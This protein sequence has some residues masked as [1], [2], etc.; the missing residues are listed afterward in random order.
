MSDVAFIPCSPVAPTDATGQ[1]L[2][3]DPR[4]RTET[5]LALARGID[6]DSAYDRLPVLADA[7]EEAGCDLGLLLQHC[8]HCPTHAPGC[9]AVELILDRVPPSPLPAFSPVLITQPHTP[10]SLAVGTPSPTPTLLGMPVVRVL[11]VVAFAGLARVLFGP[12]CSSRPSETPMQPPVR[13]P[14]APTTTRTP[15]QQAVIDSLL[16]RQTGRNEEWVQKLWEAGLTKPN[17]PTTTKP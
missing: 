15:E 11:W 16:T 7:L 14:A 17:T 2:H 3:F 5:V 12:G 8:R 4:W 1:P 6:A 9:W 10:R 13:Q